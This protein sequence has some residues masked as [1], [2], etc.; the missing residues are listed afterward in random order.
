MG[1]S[2]KHT[3]GDPICHFEH[4][5]HSCEDAKD[6]DEFMETENQGDNQTTRVYLENSC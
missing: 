6:K 2:T 1:H 5:S 4:F 3:V